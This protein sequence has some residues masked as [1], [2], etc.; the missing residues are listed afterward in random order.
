M[1]NIHIYQ[2][3]LAYQ[4]LHKFVGLVRCMEKM[5]IKFH[6]ISACLQ[7]SL[8]LAMAEEG[9]GIQHSLSQYVLLEILDLEYLVPKL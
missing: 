4:E 7:L 2:R 9:L 1:Q 6:Q 5:S 3:N 8:L